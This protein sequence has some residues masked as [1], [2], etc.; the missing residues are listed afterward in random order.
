MKNSREVECLCINTKLLVSLLSHSLEPLYIKLEKQ[1]Q[2]NI[3]IPELQKR[4]EQL[5]KIREMKG[6][7][8]NHTDI[9]QHEQKYESIVRQRMAELEEERMRKQANKDYDPTKFKT[10]INHKVHEEDELKRR[11]DLEKQNQR[12]LLSE[13]MMSYGEFVK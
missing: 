8:L 11:H 7:P 13:K 9:L 1:F 5:K 6:K 2:K 12:K 3:E 10:R 4:K